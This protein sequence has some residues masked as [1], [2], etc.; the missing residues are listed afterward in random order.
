MNQILPSGPTAMPTGAPLAL[1][2]VVTP[3]V[4]SVTVAAHAAP[5]RTA[6]A[7]AAMA[8]LLRVLSGAPSRS[9]TPG[10]D[11]LPGARGG[12]TARSPS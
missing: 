8:T 3:P 9:R 2:P 10:R 7:R 5:P 1:K 11:Y 4:S 6:Q 12:Q